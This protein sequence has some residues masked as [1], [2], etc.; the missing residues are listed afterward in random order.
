[1]WIE[2][3]LN[4]LSKTIT[5]P[6]SLTNRPFVILPYDIQYGGIAEDTPSIS[7]DLSKSS[8]KS[9]V[10]MTSRENELGSI[11]ILIIGK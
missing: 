2:E 9:C 5:Y 3:G 6:I 10:I 4:E 7:V 8:S 1:M 11:R